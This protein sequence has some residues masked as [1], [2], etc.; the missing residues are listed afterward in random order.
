MEYRTLGSSGLQVSV[1]GLGCNNFGG[2]SS[3]ESAI[4]VV[5]KCLDMGITF[6][7]TADTYPPWGEPGKSEEFLGIALRPH[8]RE[9]VIATKIN[10]RVGEGPYRLGT[11]RKHLM[12]EVEDCLRRLDT[13]YIDLLQ[14][15]AFDPSTPPEETLRALDDLVRSGKMRYIGCSNYKAWQ[16]V[17][18][19][20]LSRTEHLEP[21]ISA[22]NFY[23]LLQ[24]DI[25][26]E[27]LPACEQYGVGLLPYFPLYRGF[28]TGKYRPDQPPPPDARMAPDAPFMDHARSAATL[29]PRNFEA[30]LKLERFA[31]ERGHTMVELAFSWLASHPVIGS[32]IAGASR[33]E[34]VEENARAADW[35]LTPQEMQEVDELTGL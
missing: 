11:S 13:D 23:N 22:Q 25:E 7:D 14:M 29:T 28:L 30:L 27:L 32:I 16:L 35:R 19:R 15:H 10:G 9:V 6:F 26:K 34:Q 21:M 8:R 17:E 24:R 31:E 2:R 18:A 3:L 12:A 33:P 1:V 5:N 20:W 4:A